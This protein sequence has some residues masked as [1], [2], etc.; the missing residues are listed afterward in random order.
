M[1]PPAVTPQPVVQTRFAPQPTKLSPV[2]QITLRSNTVKTVTPDLTTQVNNL[3]PNSPNTMGTEMKSL[4]LS[5]EQTQ[6]PK[7]NN[8]NEMEL[9]NNV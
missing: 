7:P 3:S 8:L 4:L 1:N 5:K 9:N 2:P 6:S